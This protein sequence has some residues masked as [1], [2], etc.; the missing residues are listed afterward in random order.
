MTFREA[1]K[2]KFKKKL[3]LPFEGTRTFTSFFKDKQSERNQKTIGIKAFL[4]IFA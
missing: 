2:T 1:T 4:T 3:L